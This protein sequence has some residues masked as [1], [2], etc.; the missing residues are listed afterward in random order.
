MS[1]LS[2][3]KKERNRQAKK[4]TDSKTKQLNKNAMER[5]S[6]W[7]KINY[8]N[9]TFGGNRD[10]HLIFIDSFFSFIL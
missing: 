1:K 3:K 2:K 5:K 8:V 10:F 7:F 4:V 6:I 9:V